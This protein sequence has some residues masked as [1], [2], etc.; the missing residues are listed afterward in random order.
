MPLAIEQFTDPTLT[1]GD[2]FQGVPDLVGPFRRFD[3]R[4]ARTLV[5]N[6]P[7]SVGGG[8]ETVTG[9]FF[10]DPAAFRAVPTGNPAKARNGNLGRN[11]FDGPGINQWDLTLIKRVKLA[12]TRHFELRA[13]ISNLF[14][15]ALF[16]PPIT[17]VDDASLMFGQVTQ[18]APGRVIQ[19]SLRY[20][21]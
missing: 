2:I 11:L 9:A 3:P 4:R 19:F 21:F 14:N 18:A 13:D 8:T 10:F 15:H 12:D 16:Y 17:T 1:S 20:G 6:R 5:V 7:E